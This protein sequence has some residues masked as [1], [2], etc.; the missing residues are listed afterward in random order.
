MTW[1]RLK[2]FPRNYLFSFLYWKNQRNDKVRYANGTSICLADF[3]ENG[4]YT[5]RDVQTIAEGSNTIVT[6]TANAPAGQCDNCWAIYC[7]ECAN[8][9]ENWAGASA[10]IRKCPE[11]DSILQLKADPF[12]RS[13]FYQEG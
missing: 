3:N 11:C 13:K 5:G 1:P 8:I 10:A 2:R 12:H 7:Q 6:Y 4:E 9:K